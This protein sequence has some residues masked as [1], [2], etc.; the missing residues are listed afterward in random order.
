[1]KLRNR[2]SLSIIIGLMFIITIANIIINRTFTRTFQEY[3]QEQREEEFRALSKD[4]SDIIRSRDGKLLDIALSTY[5]RD[6]AVNI[7]ILDLDG[8]AVA[9][10]QSIENPNPNQYVTKEYQLIDLQNQPVGELRLSYEHSDPL[11]ESSVR[12]FHSRV[13]SSFILIGVSTAI[14]G[15]GLS[16]ALAARITSPIAK[17]SSETNKLR[18]KNYDLVLP[19]SHIPE[20]QALS[21][22]ISYLAR[23]LQTQE[24]VRK[25]Y[26]Q[27]ISHELRTPLTNLQLHIEGIQD[28]VIEADDKTLQ[29]LLDEV[30]RLG[31]M[32]DKLRSSFNDAQKVSEYRP[33]NI[34]LSK[35]VESICDSM[36]QRATK[37]GATIKTVIEP[38]INADLDPE[39]ITQVLYN[40]ISNAIKAVD[41]G[42]VIRVSLTKLP[43]EILLAVR[44]NGVGI[45]QEDLPRIFERFYRVDSS[46]NATK[47]GHG[48]GLSITKNLV[49]TMGASIS[50]TST[51]GKGTEFTV[52]FPTQQTKRIGV[53]RR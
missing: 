44:D 39:F 3:L 37:V 9:T 15:A 41:D 45:K 48:L 14:I 2:F 32:I 27:D 46:R 22:D 6:S 28:G 4:L 13:L 31:T 7:E 51:V 21:D 53:V 5:A 25:D 52:S 43:A 50:V 40:L 26:A 36:D 30:Q 49:E 11:L 20:L 19:Q 16:Y 10:Y 47:G 23:S 38:N 24:Q 29:T 35:K 8:K 17:M 34:D 33:I 42:G 18:E 12:A 1:M